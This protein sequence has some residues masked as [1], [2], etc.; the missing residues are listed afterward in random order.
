MAGIPKR[1][2]F[3]QFIAAIKSGDLERFE[4]ILIETDMWVSNSSYTF[5]NAQD[6]VL[7]CPK[8]R[9]EILRTLVEFGLNVSKEGLDAE[10]MGIVRKALAKGP[11]WRVDAFEL[12]VT[13]VYIVRT[14]AWGIYFVPGDLQFPILYGGNYD[15]EFPHTAKYALELFDI[16]LRDKRLGEIAGYAEWFRPFLVKIVNGEDFAL[17]DVTSQISDKRNIRY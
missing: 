6:A 9:N 11:Q 5:G 17:A 2:D 1:K 7:S 4:E 3:A 15:G 10:T 12:G 16:D 13:E 14:K 8:N